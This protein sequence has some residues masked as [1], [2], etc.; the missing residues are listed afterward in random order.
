MSGKGH[1]TMAEYMVGLQKDQLSFILISS[2]TS[3]G[4][5]DRKKP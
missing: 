3:Q 4:E 2:I 1:G 5:N